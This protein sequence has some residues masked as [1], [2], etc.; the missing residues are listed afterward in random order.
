MEVSCTA[1]RLFITSLKRLKSKV[2]FCNTFVFLYSFK[3]HHLC[4]QI[5]LLREK[6]V[7]VIPRYKTNPV[8]KKGPVCVLAS[9]Y[10]GPQKYTARFYVRR[11]DYQKLKEYCASLEGCTI[12][13]CE[14]SGCV[15]KFS[16]GILSYIR[17]SHFVII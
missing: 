2:S 15:P 10:D 16:S 14:T 6:S 5:A 1:L 12:A 3:T 4:A 17:Y 8:V 9:S 7:I 13:M 11:E